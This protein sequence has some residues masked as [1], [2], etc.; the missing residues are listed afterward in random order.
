MSV[1]PI[2][3]HKVDWY[4]VVGL[5]LLFWLCLCV[6]GVKEQLADINY[7][8]ENLPRSEWFDGNIWIRNDLIKVLQ[9]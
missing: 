8:I 2:E 6:S 7:T 5:V 4:K 9:I 1:K 3:W